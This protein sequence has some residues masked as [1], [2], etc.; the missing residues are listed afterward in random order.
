[1]STSPPKI[2]EARTGEEAHE[3]HCMRSNKD[4]NSIEGRRQ[5]HECDGLNGDHDPTD[6]Q[7]RSLTSMLAD[8]RRGSSVDVVE[9]V[10]PEG[11]L[12]SVSEFIALSEGLPPFLPGNNYNPILAKAENQSN[13]HT[14]L[15]DLFP[16]GFTSTS[17]ATLLLPPAAATRPA[18]PDSASTT[19]IPAGKERELEGH[20]MWAC[21]TPAAVTSFSPSGVATDN[22]GEAWR[23][24]STDE[25]N[26]KT[27]SHRTSFLVP[28]VDPNWASPRQQRG[29]CGRQQELRHHKSDADSKFR[30][31]IRKAEPI[32][33]VSHAAMTTMAGRPPVARAADGV[34]AR[35]DEPLTLVGDGNHGE[36]TEA[37]TI[38]RER[39]AELKQALDR[40]VSQ[41]LQKEERV[42]ERL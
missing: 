12:E 25:A 31:Y 35:S 30:E 24:Q 29:S 34:V 32:D 19:S 4:I 36:T 42:R 37:S 1:M 6:R 23:R 8:P 22:R 2:A 21:F 14:F 13:T 33:V 38:G 40:I 17:A 18:H 5:Q 39:E 41:L 3:G 15:T 10:Q 26:D 9:T 20:Q 7:P 16:T 27:T 28:T 11:E